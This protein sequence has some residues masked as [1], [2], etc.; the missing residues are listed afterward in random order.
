MSIPENFLKQLEQYSELSHREKEIFLEIFGRS[1]SRVDVTQKLNIS[2]S[3]LNTCLSGIYKKFS[4]IGNGPVKESRLREHLSKRYS[5]QKP[6]GHLTT[7]EI[8]NSI[9][10]LVQD[11][12][13]QVNSYI[14]EKCGTMRVLDMPKPIKLTGKQGIYTNVNILEEITGRRR[15][16]M[17][18]LMQTCDHDNFE[19]P[20]L[21]GVKQ[22]RVSGLEVVKS[23]S[24][25]MVLGKPGAGKS[26][27]LK[28]LAM[29]CIEGRFQANRVPL[30]I[31]L[32]DFAEAP[33]Q[34]DI[35]KYIAE[36]LSNCGVIDASVTV[37]KLLN[38]GKA[39]VLLDGL[40]EVR[41]EDTKRTLLQIRDFSDQFHTNQF[42][43]TCRI[44]AKEY[45]FETFTEV[46]MADFD[47]KQ[48]AIFA[49]NWFQFTDSVKGERFI[50]KVKENKSIQE[51]A[52]SPLLLTLLCLVFGDS[53]DF[54][55]NRSELYQ[56]GLDVLLKKWDAKRNI[57]RDQ[58]YKNLSLQRKED[59]L[60]QIGLTTFEQK[61]YFFKQKTAEAYIVDFIRNL[62]NADT[63]PD[64]LRL[65][66][67][68]VL[69]SIEAQHGLLVERAKG[70]YSFSHLTF[71]EYF[72]ASEIV[73]NSA[74]ESLLERITEKRWREVFL[75]TAGMMRKADDLMQS[76]K[77]KIDGLISTDEQLQNFMRW[78]EQKSS[79]A[80][81]PYPPAQV[82]GVYLHLMHNFILDRDLGL[83]D[84]P[85]ILLFDLAFTGTSDSD[86]FKACAPTI[87]GIGFSAL[88]FEVVISFEEKK[89]CAGRQESNVI[90]D[91]EF[92]SNLDFDLERN[93][94]HE[95]QILLDNLKS[96]LPPPEKDS[97][98]FQKWWI[99]DG[100]LW[101][102]Q[103][104]SVMIEH[105]NIGHDWQFNE[106]QKTLLQQYYYANKLLIDCLNS[107]CYVSREVRQEIEDTLLLPNKN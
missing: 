103:L 56:E 90:F 62:R 68:A 45:T 79:L 72:A 76:M 87:C 27:F 17:A 39:L 44:A 88:S 25:L 33:K 37:E 63:N 49:Q 80:T 86:F 23:H 105:C 91:K 53:G 107:D 84:L 89:M 9:D 73:A 60:S 35:F 69:K 1:K 30:F 100:K 6:S 94:S 31:T 83:T 7:D 52:S 29:Q 74:Y 26:T 3:N 32:K 104:K 54:P 36:Q 11:I 14:K 64:A 12:R 8:N 57:E 41:E 47:E 13:K 71:H 42:V 51:L 65:D 4:I 58:V 78:V 10:T 93:P 61:D 82:R 99:T 40:D 106:A 21:S 101:T 16:K 98:A 59:L 70:I 24:K 46:E 15:L 18:E 85:R 34:P 66:S 81:V 97:K 75:L 48:I 67:E 28:Y 55:A 50:Q 95:L 38:Q 92:D 2:L 20:G 22:K 43:I 19:R 96:Q 5:Q 77:H 102:E